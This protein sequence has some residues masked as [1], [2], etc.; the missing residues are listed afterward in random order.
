MMS[1]GCDFLMRAGCGGVGPSWKK[2]DGH[3]EEMNLV[4]FSRD[5]GLE[6]RVEAGQ[7]A[8]DG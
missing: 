6:S 4:C 2:R 5:A 3:I 1:S 7:V 8:D